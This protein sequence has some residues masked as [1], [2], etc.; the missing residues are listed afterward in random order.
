MTK[1]TLHKEN[2]QWLLKQSTDVKIAMLESHLDICRLIVNEVLEEEV[3]SLC[4]E[5]YS[6]DKPH[7]GRYSRWG[8]NPGSVRIGEH[9][10]TIQVPRVFDHQTNAVKS[11]ESY[12]R[13][14]EIVVDDEY[15]LRGIMLGLSVRDFADLNS[16]PS[17]KALTR[18]SVDA[19][20]IE[21]SA[22]RLKEFE[23]R[24]YDQ[25]QFIAL[26]V[27]GKYLA[28][29]QILLALGVTAQ[30]RKLP[31]GFVQTTN[32]NSKPCADL[33]SDLIERGLSINQ[34]LLCVV[35]GSKGLRKAVSDVFGA[36]A[37]V[38]RCQWHKREN[39]LSYLPKE[40]HVLLKHQ[41][42]SAYAMTCYE[43]AHQ[44]LEELAKEIER[45]N[46]SAANSLREGLSE[47]LTLHRLAMTEFSRSFA[48]TNCI[49]SLN[50]QI[51]S[52]TR[53][54]KRWTSSDQRHRWVAIGLLE[55]EQRMRKV[56]NHQRLPH[57]QRAIAE[58]VRAENFN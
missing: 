31:L 48:T 1:P 40:D 45:R 15:L 33:F 23:A 21:R 18:S 13:L 3:T 30:G 32:E 12:E 2:L 7:A 14:R 53:K 38:Q 26:F 55:A 10:L 16:N 6:H 47:T 34:G 11:L 17:A 29:E 56:D 51:G 58:A 4:G 24:R 46:K 8:Y 43:Q 37:L 27:D 36:Q 19:A 41:L 57:L 39:V 54:V 22:E 5:K 52:A 42:Q 28:G 49:E 44:E 35:D 25:E 20:F 9:R 50:S